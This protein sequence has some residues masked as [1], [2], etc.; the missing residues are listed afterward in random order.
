MISFPAQQHLRNIFHSIS[1]QVCPSV[2]SRNI[3]DIRT[4]IRTGYLGKQSALT[5]IATFQHQLQIVMG[6]YRLHLA[7]LD[8]I[9]VYQP[10][11]LAIFAP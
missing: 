3:Q 5:G 11:M 2:Y 8:C 7:E 9:I 10:P 1:I 6:I 4:C